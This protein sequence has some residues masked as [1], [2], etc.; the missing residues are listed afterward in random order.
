MAY[1]Q[2]LLNIKNEYRGTWV[3]LLVGR[4]TSAQ[5]I[6]LWFMGSSP[7][8]GCLL[9]AQSL[10]QIP[11]PPL[12]APPPFVHTCALSLKNKH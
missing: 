6:I 8:L 9:S 4:S 7:M 3:T 5:L 11:C 10:L 2:I 12:S 1:W